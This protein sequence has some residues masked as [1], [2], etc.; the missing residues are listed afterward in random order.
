MALTNG[1]DQDKLNAIRKEKAIKQQKELKK[2]KTKK[3]NSVQTEQ[4]HK[5][6]VLDIYNNLSEEDKVAFHNELKKKE[7]RENYI[8][9]LK[10]VHKDYKI[11]KFHSML[12]LIFQS[13]IK[14]AE[15]GE[16]VKIGLSTPPQHG[17]S[18]GNITKLVFR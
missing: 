16:I 14:R 13:A 7:I 18:I 2:L 6:D 15:K 10:Y 1:I 17:K 11:T 8:D 12:A 4:E 5:E 9:Y 3:V